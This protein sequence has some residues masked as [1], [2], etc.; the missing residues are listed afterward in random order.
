MLFVA[1]PIAGLVSIAA[2]EDDQRN[3]YLARVTHAFSVSN[4]NLASLPRTA[5]CTDQGAVIP[6]PR[7]NCFEAKWQNKSYRIVSG[8]GYKVFLVDGDSA[9]YL[10][11][12][13]GPR[14]DD[15]VGISNAHH[16]SFI[17][18][19]LQDAADKVKTR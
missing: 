13:S 9:E 15:L 11:T 19:A 8:D 2:I 3:E 10:L 6:E 18:L 12:V 16:A 1:A 7:L 14:G 17:A 4:A 5:A